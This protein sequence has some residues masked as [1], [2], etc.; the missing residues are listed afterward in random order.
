MGW[1]RNKALTTVLSPAPSLLWWLMA[2]VA[3]AFIGALLFILHASGTVK[4]LVTLNIWWLSLTP[5]GLWMLLFFQRGW[6]WDLEVI[7]QSSATLLTSREACALIRAREMTLKG[8]R[9]RF[10]NRRALEQW[11]GYA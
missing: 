4:T 5:V 3:M 10:K 2:G 11:S 7:R 6:L 9:S 8:P 1:Q